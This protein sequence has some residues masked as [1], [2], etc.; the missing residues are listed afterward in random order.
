MSYEW[1]VVLVWT[2][3]VLPWFQTGMTYLM[4]QDYDWQPPFF[5]WL[6]ENKEHLVAP[7]IG[8]TLAICSV[9]F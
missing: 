8:S 1:Q 2:I 9:I 5:R 6:L 4:A 7:V 3:V